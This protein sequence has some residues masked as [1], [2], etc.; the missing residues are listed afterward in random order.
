MKRKEARLLVEEFNKLHPVGSKFL[1]R[2]VNKDGVEYQWREVR[3]PAYI[4]TNHVT[5]THHNFHQPVCF[6]E[7]TAGAVSIEEGFAVLGMTW[8]GELLTETKIIWPCQICD[9]ECKE[10][11]NHIPF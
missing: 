9:G 4:M 8:H 2:S 6:I 3:E 5:G 1:W 10:I 11:W 7:G